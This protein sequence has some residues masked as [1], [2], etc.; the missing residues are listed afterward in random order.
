M[1]LAISSLSVAGVAC[2]MSLLDSVNSNEFFPSS[3]VVSVNTIG[4]FVMGLLWGLNDL[5]NWLPYLYAG[6]AVGFCG[7]F[8]TFSSWMNSV[9]NDQDPV[10]QCITGLTIPF[11]VFIVGVD[12]TGS[13]D[14]E[15]IFKDVSPP[16]AAAI[17]KGCVS[18]LSLAAVLTMVTLSVT[19]NDSISN[20]DLISC[21]IG[22]IGALTR[23]ALNRLLNDK[24]KW[25]M[26]GTFSANTIAVVI[27]GSLI[28]C[29]N[30]D[31]WCEY[32]IQGICGSL[33]SVSAWV[34]DTVRIYKETKPWAYFYC[35][36]SVG[37]GLAIM[38]PFK[39]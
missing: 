15:A 10:V 12:L 30:G 18:L 22:P 32:S 8:T 24:I 16:I 26:L 17:D 14:V 38:I 1:V 31:N 28:H 2:R 33:S 19:D 27:M 25:F 3:T 36:L 4:S 29:T 20:G 21:A 11:L 5:I 9:M 35:L 7:S 13:I 23:F 34:L 6:L 39:Q 37:V